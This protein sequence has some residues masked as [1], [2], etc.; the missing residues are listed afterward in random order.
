MGR[1]ARGW[2]LGGA[3]NQAETPWSLMC[4]KL[5]ILLW[6]SGRATSE[7]SQGPRAATPPPRPNQLQI[8]F[9]LSPTQTRA[10]PAPWPI[11][12]PMFCPLPLLMLHP[13]HLEHAYFFYQIPQDSDD[14]YLIPEAL[15]DTLCSLFLSPLSAP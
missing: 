13:L 14:C 11:P 1:E 7:L 10:A 5:R 9:L 12:P 2:V 6:C 3:R 8:S 4:L 15:S